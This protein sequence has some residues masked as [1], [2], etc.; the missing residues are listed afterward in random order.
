MLEEM[1]DLLDDDL[2]QVAIA[3][4]ALVE[5]VQR[6]D[7]DGDDLLVGPRLVLHQQRADRPR[8]DHDT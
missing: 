8:A 6:I 5:G 4:D 1:C 7:G 2:R 3:A